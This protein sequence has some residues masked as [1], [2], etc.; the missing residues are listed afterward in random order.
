MY[1]TFAL[2]NNSK[3]EIGL[4]EATALDNGIYGDD[5]SHDFRKYMRIYCDSDISTSFSN[6]NKRS[7]ITFFVRCSIHPVLISEDENSIHLIFFETPNSPCFIST[8]AFTS[9]AHQCNI[10]RDIFTALKVNDLLSFVEEAYEKHRHL[11]YTAR[12]QW[13][14]YKHKSFEYQSQ[15]ITNSIGLIDINGKQLMLYYI[16]ESIRDFYNSLQC[17][18]IDSNREVDSV[19]FGFTKSLAERSGG[20]GPNITV[21]IKQIVESLIENRNYTSNLTSIDIASIFFYVLQP[22]KYNLYSSIYLDIVNSIRRGSLWN[23]P[24]AT[25]TLLKRAIRKNRP[26]TPKK[27]RKKR[28]KTIRKAAG[29]SQE[30]GS[31]RISC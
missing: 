8:G 22:P 26:P 16:N 5:I 9:V 25:E 13:K 21:P 30:E 1:E 3:S 6:G 20:T 18:I 17:H 19:I 31:P 29:A 11:Y 15:D 10:N 24:T 14:N 4:I 7:R 28:G 12:D 23:I 2:P 27:E